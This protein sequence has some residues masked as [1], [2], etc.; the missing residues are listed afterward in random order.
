MFLQVVTCVQCTQ[1]YNALC[2]VLGLL[3]GIP[4]LGAPFIGVGFTGTVFT[5]GVFRGAGFGGVSVVTAI[6]FTGVSSGIGSSA[7][8][9]PAD[10]QLAAGEGTSASN[11][12]TTSP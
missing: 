9:E 2:G 10:P 8:E 6:C 1:E 5:G 7:V 4:L 3:F 12:L 11:S